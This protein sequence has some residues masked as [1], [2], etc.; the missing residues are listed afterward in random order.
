MTSYPARLAVAT[1]GM[2][3]FCVA[4]F[5]INHFWLEGLD[6]G[7]VWIKWIVGVVILG[8]FLVFAVPAL[9]W[10]ESARRKR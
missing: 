1:V 4:F 8:G 6:S 2:V 5:A 3:A 9:R 10:A 7:Q